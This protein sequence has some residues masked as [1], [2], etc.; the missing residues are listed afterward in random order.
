MKWRNALGIICNKKVPPKNKGKPYYTTIRPVM[1]YGM[2]SWAV[3]CQQEHKLNIV[4]MK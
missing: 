3:K 4:K 2:V 1:L